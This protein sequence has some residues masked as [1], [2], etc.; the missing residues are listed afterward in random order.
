MQINPHRVTGGYSPESPMGRCRQQTIAWGS[1]RISDQ[2]VLAI[3]TGWFIAPPNCLFESFPRDEHSSVCLLWEI[4]FLKPR[5]QPVM[6]W[7]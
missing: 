1:P 5:S 7:P 6:P 3:G 4:A 2:S